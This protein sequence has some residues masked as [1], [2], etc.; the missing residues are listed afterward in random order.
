MKYRFELE[1]S[2]VV[3]IS[4]GLG[5]LPYEKVASVIFNVQKQINL[6]NE[7]MRNLALVK[8]KKETGEETKAAEGVG[9][10]QE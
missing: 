4:E 2:D 9:K 10:T 3:L 5:K 1:G 6:Q 8:G 7:A